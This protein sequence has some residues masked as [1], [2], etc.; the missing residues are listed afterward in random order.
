MHGWASKR[1]IASGSKGS[2]GYKVVRKLKKMGRIAR[3]LTESISYSWPNFAF[4][5]VQEDW[6]NKTNSG[7]IS[8]T[9]TKL[10]II[11]CID[12]SLFCTCG[13]E[14]TNYWHWF[15]RLFSF[16]CFFFFFFPQKGVLQVDLDQQENTQLCLHRNNL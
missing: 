11:I 7:E 6:K 15:N 10:D 13:E 5:F 4:T 2:N 3:H 16:Q 8:A 14:A 9:T 1:Y 12:G